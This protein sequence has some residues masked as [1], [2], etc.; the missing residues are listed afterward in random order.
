MWRPLLALLMWVLAG[1]VWASQE[2]EPPPKAEAHVKVR[3]RGVRD[4]VEIGRAEDGSMQFFLVTDQGEILVL[5]PEEFA[6]R[7]YSEQSRQRWW[8]RFLNVTSPIGIAWVGLGFL[9]QFLFT[10]RM[11]V[12]WLVS[13]RERRSVVPP[14]FWWMSLGGATM[15]L[16][17]F[18]WR[19]DVVGVV[20]QAT[21]WLIY[22]RNLWLI[23]R[24]GGGAPGVSD[25]PGPEPELAQS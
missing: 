24:S 21:G 17:Y 20:G 23:Y 5:T 16:V 11:L 13:E 18:V 15:L 12:Q 1:G 7:V 19:R 10:G 9:G 25:D 4:R 2:P 3:L 22:L 14:V 6:V 8:N